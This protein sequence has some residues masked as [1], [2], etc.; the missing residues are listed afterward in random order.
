[1]ESIQIEDLYRERDQIRRL[2]CALVGESDADDIVQEAMAAALSRKAPPLH[3]GR[4]LTGVTRHLSWRR[5]TERRSR[6]W[7]L[8]RHARTEGWGQGQGSSPDELVAEVEAKN[9]L[10]RAVLDLDEPYRSVLLWRYYEDLSIEEISRRSGTPQ[11]TTRTRIERGLARLRARMNSERGPEWRMALVPLLLRRPAEKTLV[12]AVAASGVMLMTFS[13]LKWII[14]ATTA[15]ALIALL[16]N[17]NDPG[18][19]LQDRTDLSVRRVEG[20]EL[21]AMDTLVGPGVL[22]PA[23]RTEAAAPGPDPAA[24]PAAPAAPFDSRLQDRE[25]GLALAGVELDVSIS[26]TIDAVILRRTRSYEDTVVTDEEGRFALPAP[27]NPGVGE[28]SLRQAQIS[29]QHDGPVAVYCEVSQAEDGAWI[30]TPNVDFACRVHLPLPLTAAQR[31][32]ATYGLSISDG[33]LGAPVTVRLKPAATLEDELTLLVPR[34]SLPREW[35]EG[36]SVGTIAIATTPGGPSFSATFETL[37]SFGDDPLEA[38]VSNTVIHGVRVLDASTLEP[39]EGADVTVTPAT[40]KFAFGA[41]SVMGLTD[42]TGTTELISV[43]TA[44]AVLRVQ[45]LGY[46]AYEGSL[47]ANPGATTEVLLEPTTGVRSVEV[48]VRSKRGAVPSIVWCVAHRADGRPAARE[49]GLPE[50]S[51]EGWVFRSTLEKVPAERCAIE[52]ELLGDAYDLGRH[53]LLE[54]EESSLTIDLGEARELLPVLVEAPEGVRFEYRQGVDTARLSVTEHEGPTTVREAPP[55]GSSVTWMVQAEGYVPMVGTESDWTIEDQ[56][57]RRVLKLNASFEPGWGAA[58]RAVQAGSAEDGRGGTL[59][60]H[61]RALEPVAGVVLLDAP[62]GREIGVTDERGFAVIQAGQRP[63]AI[64]FR[65]DGQ[66]RQLTLLEDRH[67]YELR[68]K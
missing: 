68:L 18:I 4:W 32:A 66:V 12:G 62:D 41:E 55:E 37:P 46:A 3:W 45:R 20:A 1:M 11:S 22:E 13:M 16:A 60:Y 34:F 65:I 10:E 28:T 29:A 38:E 2:A 35:K 47:K 5:S 49:S 9:A 8:E 36:N 44:D 6:A 48:T 67:N 24:A 57:E 25:S 14:A 56:G 27:E 19:A 21:A 15:A 39:L 61:L 40:A 43:P 17:L 7:D 54:P 53:W 31:A 51:G 50:P 59:P 52:V 42:A 30:F 64:W 63:E 58:V 23:A 33:S 26:H